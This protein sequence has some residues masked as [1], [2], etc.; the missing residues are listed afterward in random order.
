MTTKPDRAWIVEQAEQAA[1]VLGSDVVK[2]TLLI[3]DMDGKYVPEFDAAFTAQGMKVLP[4]GPRR[5]QMNAWA[6]RY[7]RSVREECLRH[8]IVMGLR[9]LRHLLLCW[10]TYYNTKRPHQGVGNRPLEQTQEPTNVLPFPGS[11]VV[12][13]EQLGGV[14]KHYTL[15]RAA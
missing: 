9:H 7:V 15:R 10:N 2:P 11:E 14:I 6:E 4:V 3:R 8:F 1:K 13:E 5:P 12:C